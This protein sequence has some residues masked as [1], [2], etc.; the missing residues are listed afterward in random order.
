LATSFGTTA[1]LFQ[2]PNKEFHLFNLPFCPSEATK[3]TQK[4]REIHP[5]SLTPTIKREKRRNNK[6]LKL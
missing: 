1:E 3:Q 6:N 4:S 2:N 5:F